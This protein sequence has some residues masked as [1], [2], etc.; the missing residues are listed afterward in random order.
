MKTFVKVMVINALIFCFASMPVFASEKQTVLKTDITELSQVMSPTAAASTITAPDG[1][2]YTLLGTVRRGTTLKTMLRSTVR[3]SDNV[4]LKFY[5][6]NNNKNDLVQ[7]NVS[8]VPIFGGTAITFSFMNYYDPLST[9][10]LSTLT[11]TT[12]YR[13][14]IS[15]N[16]TGTSNQ[17][18]VYY[19]TEKK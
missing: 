14:E 3:A 12:P 11:G 2:T 1:K 10:D 13:I 17:G 16:A 9:I 4:Q 7:G 5:C 19:R 18:T 8:A 6:P 15:I